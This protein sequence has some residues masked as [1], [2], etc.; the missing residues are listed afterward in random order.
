M[1][2]ASGAVAASFSA[3]RPN[4]LKYSCWLGISRPSIRSVCKR[5][6][7]TM[8]APEMPS[9]KLVKTGTPKLSIFAG[10]KVEGLTKRNSAPIAP[11]RYRFDRA[12][13]LFA[14]SPQIAIFNPSIRPNRR[15]IV[16][17]SR[18]ACVGCSWRPSPALIT[19]PST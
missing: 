2:S 7:M 6:I 11:S 4:S 18:R 16:S 8:S 3:L 19:Q 13:R 10:N 17:A 15:N 5:S 14:I 12:T 1:M 9:T